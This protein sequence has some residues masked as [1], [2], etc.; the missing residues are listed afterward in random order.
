MD[1]PSRRSCFF[2]R[3]HAPE[4]THRSVDKERHTENEEAGGERQQGKRKEKIIN[5]HPNLGAIRVP[6]CLEKGLEI[7][8]VT[9]KGFKR[10]SA[11]LVVKVAWDARHQ[12][13]RPIDQKMSS[14]FEDGA[15]YLLV[16]DFLPQELDSDEGTLIDLENT[17]MGHA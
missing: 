4:Q 12:Q 6:N 16:V 9:P 14:I 1:G 2:R 10:R 15:M 7:A 13:F 8:A 17:S 11:M 5:E 3:L